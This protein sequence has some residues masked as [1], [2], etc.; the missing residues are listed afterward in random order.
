[1]TKVSKCLIEGVVESATSREVKLLLS[2]KKS[3]TILADSNVYMRRFVF[4]FLILLFTCGMQPVRGAALRFMNYTSAD[5]LSSNTVLSMIQDRDG[6]IWIGTTN[7][8]NRFDGCTF[9]V[10]KRSEG[11]P[12]NQI[13]ALEADNAG[14]LWIG[15]SRGLCLMEGQKIKVCS[16]D[17]Y[18]R[19]LLC[20]TDGYLWVTYNDWR[21]EKIDIS[22]ESFPVLARSTY[23]TGLVE[24]DYYYNQLYADARGDIW[25][26][27]R[28]VAG[29]KVIDR[30]TAQLNEY[31]GSICLGSFAPGRNGGLIAFND[32]TTMLQ[33]FDGTRFVNIGSMPVAH[34]RLLRDG[35][36]RLWAAGYSGITIVDE[37]DPINSE[38]LRHETSDPFS[39]GPSEYY[40]VLQD[41]HGNIWFGG[42]KGIAVY[43]RLINMVEN[44]LQGD[45]ITA[46][47]EASDGRMWV[48]TKEANVTSLYEDSQ[49]C[50]YTGYW[51]LGKGF[52]RFDPST[53]LTRRYVLRGEILPL[54]DKVYSGDL[55]GANW[56]NGF[57]E[58][59]RGNFWCITWEGYGLNLF[60]RTKGEFMPPRWLSPFKRPT[61]DVDSPTYVSS[62]LGS[63]A[64]EDSKGRLYYGTTFAG[65]NIIDPDTRLVRKYITDD[66]ITDL[67]K[68]PDDRVYA[69]TRHGLFVLSDGDSTGWMADG[70]NIN[71]VE[72]DSNG[73]IWAGTDEGLIFIDTDS[74]YG[75]V[76][77]WIGISQDIFS[78]RVSCPLHDGSLAFGGSSGYDTFNPDTLIAASSGMHLRACDFTLEG[79]HL[80]L[81]FSVTDIPLCRHVEYRYKLEGYD[82]DWISTTWR[83]A[84]VNYSGLAPGRYTLKVGCTDV[85]GRW[86]H[87]D[88]LSLPIVI[89]PPLLLRWPFIIFYLLVAGSLLWLFVWLRERN[90][91]NEKARLEEAVNIKTSE[92]RAEIET[93]NR[94]FSIISHDLKNPVTGVAQLASQL[95]AN[96]ETLDH[97]SLKSGV[98]TL[99]DVS[100][101]TWDM[102]E[103]LLLWA[104][105]QNDMIKAGIRQFPL[106]EIINRSLS[107]VSDRARTKGVGIEKQIPDGLMVS[108]D[109]QLLVTVLRNILENAVKYS[110]PGGT[111]TVLAVDSG[112]A[113]EISVNDRGPGISPDKL[114]DLFRIDKMHSTEGTMGEKGT[115]LGLIISRE[116]LLRMGAGI[117]VRNNPEGGCSITV[118]LKNQ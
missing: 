17:G 25:I 3:L 10:Y 64:I 50:I 73:R 56:Y 77:S 53:G 80:Q 86:E 11:L 88:E 41:R 47:L 111:V 108:C 117:S 33:Q 46:L 34:C 113:T 19:A 49:G 90:L 48:G 96:I 30:Q 118:T 58:D 59:S 114:D 87:G 83:Q 109:R 75:K 106:D 112:S 18:V 35:Q 94:F 76:P 93:R 4:T 98:D 22:D 8:L 37:D 78:E 82:S 70:M 101:N 84:K 51:E 2:C 62:R 65:L 91:R 39:P 72:T 20:D 23:G 31:E 68:T 103:D 54:Q 40:C 5:G 89:R 67:A 55:I 97:E 110:Y 13:N 79:G 44:H 28:M 116:L 69:G 61:P 52:D 63:C 27:G 26:G 74:T 85:F 107:N 14:R 29:K 6:F 43:T 71:S 45:N 104:V 105:S 66:Y 42:D 99:R 60:D 36:G 38:V 115:G 1:M 24:G 100:S 12:D 9:K 16:T 7:G 57:M 81:S 92:L 21:V 102:L 95:S 15:T 32:F